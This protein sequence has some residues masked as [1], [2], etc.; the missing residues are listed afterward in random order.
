MPDLGDV[1]PS[2]PA[3]PVRPIDP[4]DQRRRQPRPP[5]QD[6]PVRAPDNGDGSSDDHIDEYADPRLL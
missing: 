5:P 6:K 3:R 4:K 1:Q 2:S